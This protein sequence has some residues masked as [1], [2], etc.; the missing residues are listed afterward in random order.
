MPVWKANEI[1]ILKAYCHQEEKLLDS[2]SIKCKY[3]RHA[4]RDNFSV[5]MLHHVAYHAQS[6]G[7]NI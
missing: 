3:N 6:P 7:F 2:F 5:Y 4:V 1:F